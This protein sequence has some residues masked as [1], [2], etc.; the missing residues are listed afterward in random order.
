MA[1]YIH[2]QMKKYANGLKMSFK[3][4]DDDVKWVEAAN[5]ARKASDYIEAMG[6]LL[7]Q[8]GKRDP[9]IEFALVII[10]DKNIKKD[11]KRWADSKGIVT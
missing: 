8:D 5:Q 2:E 4:K 3:G 10:K 9:V 1:N 6:D 7:Q 11:I